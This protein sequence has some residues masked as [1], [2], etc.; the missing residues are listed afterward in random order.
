[1]QGDQRGGVP[2]PA[3]RALIRHQQSARLFE[4]VSRVEWLGAAAD[5]RCRL[6][7]GDT[8]RSRARRPYLLD[9]AESG[10]ES[11]ADAY[12][13]ARGEAKW[14]DY[15]RCQPFAR[16]WVATIQASAGT[17]AS[18]GL[19]DAAFGSLVTGSYQRRRGAAE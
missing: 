2:I 4:H 18:V 15:N 19:R 8:E 6:E 9:R 16:S 14:S 10:N 12:L 5:S 17:D 1:M 11:S 13:A 7:H 3:I